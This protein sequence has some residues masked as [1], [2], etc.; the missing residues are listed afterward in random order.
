MDYFPHHASVLGV[1]LGINHPSLV[2]DHYMILPSL[3]QT[4]LNHMKPLG[5]ALKMGW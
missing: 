2:Y 3:S 4:I 1:L 5:Y